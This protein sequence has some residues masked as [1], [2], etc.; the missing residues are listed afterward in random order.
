MGPQLVQVGCEV[1][2][3]LCSSSITMAPSHLQ[4][5]KITGCSLLLIVRCYRIKNKVISAGR[6]EVIVLHV[7]ALPALCRLL[8]SVRLISRGLLL[9]QLP[10]CSP[11][12]PLVGAA[13]ECQRLFQEE[14]LCVVEGPLV[15]P[16]W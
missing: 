7:A 11:R 2:L 3:Q 9:P 10:L 5:L 8:S 1:G 12:L 14:G 13:R 16:V 6:A 15:F 4:A